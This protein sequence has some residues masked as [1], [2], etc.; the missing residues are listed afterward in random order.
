MHMARSDQVKYLELVDRL[1]DYFEGFDRPIEP[2]TLFPGEFFKY[3]IIPSVSS[4]ERFHREPS[5][6]SYLAPLVAFQQIRWPLLAFLVLNQNSRVGDCTV[7][8]TQNL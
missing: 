4:W 1:V 6:R 2:I 5:R 7:T 8:T 3:P